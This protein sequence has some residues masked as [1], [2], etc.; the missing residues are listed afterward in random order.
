MKI[1]RRVLLL[2]VCCVLIW[3]LTPFVEEAQA[4]KGLLFPIEQVSDS[5]V[6][7]NTVA[8]SNT[9]RN[10]AVAMDG[11]IY[12][13]YRNAN[14]IYVNNS[15]DR[16][17]TMGTPV[18]VS[19]DTNEPEIAVST[20]GTLYVSWVNSSGVMFAR[21]TDGG[22]SFSTPALIGSQLTSA[23]QN[24]ASTYATVHM[25]T[26]G[27]HVYILDFT[28]QYLY[29]SHDSGQTFSVKTFRRICVQRCYGG[30][31]DT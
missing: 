4:A 3:P 8:Y 10:I 13:V 5:A 27:L 19:T 1:L 11:K 7:G 26:D 21:S 20:N 29:F 28:G 25:A 18:R 9:T 24:M 17:E 15:V 30:Q 16:G 23:T 31:A 6:S 2:V 12:V 22:Q 14:G